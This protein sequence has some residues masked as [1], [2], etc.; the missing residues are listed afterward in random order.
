MNEYSTLNPT[1]NPLQTT[2]DINNIHETK[3][4]Q[5]TMKQ[6]KFFGQISL[7]PWKEG[8]NVYSYQMLLLDDC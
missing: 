6:S 1:E 7:C 2:S 8:Q 4:I 3:N 5:I